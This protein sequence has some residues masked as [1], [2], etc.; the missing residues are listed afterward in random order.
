MVLKTKEAWSV[1]GFLI[2]SG[3]SAM[4]I[5]HVFLPGTC[6][7]E[8]K[9]EMSKFKPILLIGIIALSVVI[10]Q[11]CS[12][13]ASQH[14]AAQEQLE[15]ALDIIRQAE[16]G[17]VPDDVGNISYRDYRHQVLTSAADELNEVVNNGSKDQKLS[18]QRLLADIYAHSARYAM[19][20]ATD[21][22]AAV[23]SQ[24]TRLFSYLIAADRI[25][26]RINQLSGD[27]AGIISILEDSERERKFEQ[28]EIEQRLQD[29]YDQRSDI[30]T[31]IH[32]LRDKMDA[33]AAKAREIRDQAFIVQGE[34]QYDLYERANDI[35]QGIN[36]L[37]ARIEEQQTI[38]DDLAVTIKPL[39]AEL[40]LNLKILQMLQQQI[41]DI[42]TAEHTDR[43]DMA[44]AK[45][46]LTD[47]VDVL[48]KEFN[49]II[50]Q[51]H[52]RVDT[53]L[54]AAM[55]NMGTSVAM[56]DEAVS[57]SS[58]QMKT[59]V[60]RELLA[61]QLEQIQVAMHYLMITRGM[62]QTVSI[63]TDE[64]RRLYLPETSI[65]VARL[66]AMQR[67]RNELINEATQYIERCRMLA[68]QLAPGG[69]SELL[70]DV[71]DRLVNYEQQLNQIK[72]N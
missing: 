43:Q 27:S 46:E 3:R 56:L 69:E 28:L 9:W 49:E 20:K 11:G 34:E 54:T 50:D 2:L 8:R 23:T 58:R 60:Q 19:R 36:Q 5:E 31:Q 62:T 26:K 38:I 63:V 51:Y 61:K 33:A 35:E 18:A 10:M 66:E 16:L 70:A 41:N 39:Q 12:R 53:K 6:C 17:Y 68:D 52:H 64:A 22:Y 37:A 44:G 42:E 72:V 71:P 24:S 13:E 7:N 48:K 47:Q 55:K 32:T 65:Y 25:S 59:D 57:G 30:E 21:E 4:L 14:A 29:L 45:K 40:E 1:T 15:K 67:I